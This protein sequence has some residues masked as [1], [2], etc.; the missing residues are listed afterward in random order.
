MLT[1][2]I[3]FGI[4]DGTLPNANLENVEHQAEKLCL[5]NLNTAENLKKCVMI[6]SP[7]QTIG[8]LSGENKK[9]LHYELCVLTI[10]IFTTRE[11]TAATLMVMEKPQPER[12]FQKCISS[13]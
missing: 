9:H 6:S 10:Q 13:F 4:V 8:V 7:T 1:L 3:V 2:P 11:N 12:H 5:K